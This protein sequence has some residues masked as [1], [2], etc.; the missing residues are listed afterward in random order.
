MER[1]QDHSLMYVPLYLLP[2][3][4][5]RGATLLKDP[6]F[7]TGGYVRDVLVSGLF[8]ASYVLAAKGSICVLKRVETSNNMS[9]ASTVVMA[10]STGLSALWERPSRRIELLLY[11]SQR[12]RE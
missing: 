9:L 5:F 6:V 1:W 11:V 8:L 10:A 12:V 2:R 3:L 4:L 7:F